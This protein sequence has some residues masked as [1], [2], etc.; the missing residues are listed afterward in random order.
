VN[1]TY[2]KL[3][4]AVSADG[5]SRVIVHDALAVGGRVR[6]E[7]KKE[8]EREMTQKLNAGEAREWS[9]EVQQSSASCEAKRNSTVRANQTQSKLSRDY[10]LKKKKNQS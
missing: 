9:R 3:G 7:L 6:R 1:Q 4:H 5:I 2:S 8:R 10:Y